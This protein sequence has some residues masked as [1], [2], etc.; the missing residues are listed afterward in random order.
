MKVHYGVDIVNDSPVLRPTAAQLPGDT[1]AVERLPFRVTIA[2]NDEQLRKAV[3]V[4]HAAYARHVPA[5]AERMKVPERCDL[6]DGVVV[7]LA[8]AKLDGS[9]L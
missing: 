8:E 9:P 1:T 3:T 4:R 7:L 6:E 5:F 2:R